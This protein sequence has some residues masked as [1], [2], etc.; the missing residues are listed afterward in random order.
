MCDPDELCTGN[1]NEACPTDVIEPD[2]TVCNPGSGDVCD[3]DEL[4]TGNADEGCPADVIAPIETPCTFDANV[5]TT[6]TC[7]GAGVC[8]AANNSAPC[9][10]GDACTSSD[11]CSGGSCAGGPPTDCDDGDLCTDDSCDSIDGCI[12]E[13]EPLGLVCAVAEKTKFQMRDNADDTKD[14]LKWGWNKGEAMPP[15]DLGTPLTTTSYALCVYDGTSGTP[16]HVLSLNVVPGTGWTVKT[17]DVKYK[18]KTGNADGATNVR[19]KASL[20]AGKSSAKFRAKGMSLDLPTPV[21]GGLFLN[22][23]PVVVEMLNSDGTCWTSSFS[24]EGIK[25]NLTAQFQATGN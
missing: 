18:N 4:C 15:G 3:P 13:A 19:G 16:N 8:G 7:D 12:N 1:A 11:T 25:K 20:T 17:G 21:G 24:G 10:D 2:T 22:A 6:D 9:D 23:D 5:C 14:Q